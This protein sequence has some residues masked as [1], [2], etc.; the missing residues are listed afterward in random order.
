MI[1]MQYREVPSLLNLSRFQRFEMSK[2]FVLFDS[3][4]SLSNS[5]TEQW[6]SL[7]YEKVFQLHFPTE[8][9]YFIKFSVSNEV[10]SK[11]NLPLHYTK[12]SG[13]NK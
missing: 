11:I 13:T 4:W 1:L 9:S 2:W 3:D 8:G 5:E 10:K 6:L 12:L 7:I